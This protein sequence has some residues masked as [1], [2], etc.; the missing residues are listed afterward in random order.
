MA[1]TNLSVF[2][3]SSILGPDFVGLTSSL[4]NLIARHY[5]R[6]RSV[7]PQ[8]GLFN[9]SETAMQIITLAKR[10]C[11][12]QRMDCGCASHPDGIDSGDAGDVAAGDQLGYPAGG[13]ERNCRQAAD[14]FDRATQSPQVRDNH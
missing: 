12:P 3:T 14:G 9:T 7:T 11:V 1:P 10:R 13:V 4:A 2:S 5:L 6:G 8:A